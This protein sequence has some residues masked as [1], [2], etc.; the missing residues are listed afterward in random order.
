[1][2]FPVQVGLK[3]GE[4]KV[5]STN[6]LGR[7]LSTRGVL[8]D[9]KV[10][11]WCKNGATELTAQRVVSTA[12]TNSSIEAS[13]DIGVG[14][15]VSGV[16]STTIVWTCPVTVNE[17]AG[18]TLTVAVTPGYGTYKIKSHAVGVTTAA[19]SLILEE[20][21]KLK[22]AWTSGSTVVGLFKNPYTSVV[23]SPASPAG[24]PIGITPVLIPAANYFWLQ[25]WG[26]GGVMADTSPVIGE[27]L[28]LS[29]V[30]AGAVIAATTGG[31]DVARPTLGYATDTGGGADAVTEVFITIAP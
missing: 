23:V 18:G 14:T 21:D 11:R 29:S 25:T 12:V 19:G 15:N 5:V 20:D 16:T 2:G 17:F 6:S 7:A 31:V 22:T 3:Y 9:G 30:S 27:A 4:E 24:A 10:F 1:M 13:M 8:P 28:K 26:R